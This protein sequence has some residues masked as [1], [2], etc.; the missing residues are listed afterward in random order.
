MAPKPRA[1]VSTFNP[2][3]HN[4]RCSQAASPVIAPAISLVHGSTRETLL[5]KPNIVQTTITARNKVAEVGAAGARVAVTAVADTTINSFSAT[6]T[7]KNINP[8]PK[9]RF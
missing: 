4:D 6:L 2:H 5:C 8:S 7:T 1:I 9:S 3:V